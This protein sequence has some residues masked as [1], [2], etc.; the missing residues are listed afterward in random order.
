M[1]ALGVGTQH[2]ASGGQSLPSRGS[3]LPPDASAPVEERSRVLFVD[4]EADIRRAV[5]RL[6]PRHGFAVDVADSAVEAIRLAEQ[7][8]YS[9][10]AT[11]LRMP[12][13]D[14]LSLIERLK[15]TQ[16]ETVFVLVTAAPEID[17]RR[18]VAPDAGIAQIISKPWDEEIFLQA[19]RR[20]LR[21][22]ST[23]PPPP[24][25]QILVV[26]DNPGDAL[27]VELAI[28]DSFHGLYQVTIVPTIAD[29]L[30]FLQTRTVAMV[31]T[32]LNLPDERELDTVRRLN[33]ASP[34]SP[35][36]VLSGSQDEELAFETIRC[37]AQDFIDKT[38][39]SPDGL[40]RAIRFAVERQRASKRLAH[41]A[42][43]DQLTGLANRIM[44]RERLDHAVAMARRTGSQFA[45]MFLDLDKFKPI[46][47]TYG[48]GTG[49]ALLQEIACRLT[50]AVRAC[51]T[52]ARLGGD[53][54]ALLLENVQG[55]HQVSHVVERIQRALSQPIQLG[56][57]EVSA[58]ASIGIA[59]CPN[60]TDGADELLKSADAAMYT[61]KQTS[62][63]SC[64][65]YV[66]KAYAG[67]TPRLQLQ[68]DLRLALGRNEFLL[69]YQ[70]QRD[71]RTDRIVAVE[72]LL[73]W[74]R[75]DG[76]TIWPLD[77]MP[78]LEDSGL[79]VPVG[80]WVL[81]SACR[82]IHEMQLHGIDA[83]VAVNMSAAQFESDD[84][85][86]SIQ[87][88][89]EAEQVAPSLLELEITESLLMRDT[90]RVNKTLAELK[91]LGLRLAIDDFGTGYS[92]LAYLDRFHVDALK[93]DQSFTQ[94]VNT[95]TTGASV[96]SA[97]VDLGHQLGLEVVA[98]GVER[99]EQLAFLRECGCDLAQGY[100]IG[101][102][103]SQWPP[104]DASLHITRAVYG[105]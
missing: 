58:S 5:A 82:Q 63:T 53:E 99:A 80:R 44:F 74:R 75:A 83:R 71:L 23:R 41:L 6:L 12:G 102:P 89:L 18:L 51:D 27:L 47:D 13:M 85:I 88:A 25:E 76:A 33:K 16:P 34:E 29:A 14:G 40:R 67:N 93:I 62:G 3:V 100:L 10:I 24:R 56:P 42:H 37:G 21:V 90:A 69:H 46:N 101:R 79:I 60:G 30:R 2:D 91:V 61:A 65:F 96:A 38:D 1:S 86:E 94:Q 50:T 26:E 95:G 52:V 7:Q 9:L 97:I 45:V 81:Q 77:F 72:A 49:D 4:D 48:H 92:S 104:Q 20:A 55:Q 70:P 103:M 105:G 43:H 15:V 19:C 54:F 35:I 66:P 39:L 84:L 57:Y 31:L 59:F 36:I 73:R 28:S 8:R 68:N 17:L 78:V 22:R 87:S 64:E 98:E 11:D 32:D